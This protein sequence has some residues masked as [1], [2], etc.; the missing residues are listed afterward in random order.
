MHLGEQA[1]LGVVVDRGGVGEAD[2]DTETGQLVQDQHLMG[3]VAGQAIRCQAPHALKVPA[4]GLVPQ[5]VK[6][7][8]IQARPRVTVVDETGRHL[9]ARLGHR[10]LERLDLG[11]DGALVGLALR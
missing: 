2:L 9:V 5:L 3:E 7:G 10:I 1:G 8:A 11:R 4:V 6:A